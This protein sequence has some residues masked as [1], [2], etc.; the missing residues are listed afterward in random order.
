MR[1]GVA[2]TA[3]AVITLITAPSAHAAV[4]TNVAGTLTYSATPGEDNRVT[5]VR[6]GAD[7]VLTDPGSAVLFGLPG[8]RSVDSNTLRC[9][10]VGSVS[11]VL[12]DGD[13]T[14]AVDGEL[15]VAAD[16]GTGA[17]RLAGGPAGDQLR[18]GAGDDVLVGGA[19][20]DELDGGDGAD[21]A[22]YSARVGGLVVTLDGV[23]NDGEP[24]EDD[25]VVG[26][27]IVLGGAG[28][29]VID[30]D[31]GPN[32]ISGGPGDDSLNGGDGG[33]TIDG[34][35][36]QDG[37]NALDP[38][39]DE[40]AAGEEPPDEG[41]QVSCGGGRDQVYGDDPD[42]FGADCERTTRGPA[43]GVNVGTQVAPAAAAPVLGESV[44][45]STVSGVVLVTSPPPGSAPRTRIDVP[46]APAMPLSQ[47]DEANVPV[48]SVVDTRFGTVELTV[49][50]DRDGATENGRFH[51]GPF[52]VFQDNEVGTVTD[53]ELRGGKQ[54]A[55]CPAR[56][57]GPSVARAAAR[58]P[59]RRL[60]ASAKG[61]F[62][63]RGRF[64]AASVRG[65]RWLTLD[66]CE[67]TLVRVREGAVAVDDLLRGATRLVRAG[68]SYLVR[69]R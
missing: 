44:L 20:S 60:W 32:V 4:V 28:R 36:G 23:R 22:D 17:D 55:A 19:G 16:G 9:D 53:L 66:R 11:L 46:A 42:G 35:D 18:G 25:I 13:D 50:V 14:L 12:G 1:Q 27:E 31:E 54:F 52:Q 33:D 65:T 39:A 58:R 30:G 6:D 45:V 5:L 69:S 56:Q 37:V 61:R 48:G 15:R 21:N 24:G 29:D 68:E 38:E 47:G 62:R 43:A 64:G 63:T 26:I 40:P 34:G 7:V 51:S 59:V 49:A 2:A 10:G 3:L 41:D 67:G 8:C 57:R